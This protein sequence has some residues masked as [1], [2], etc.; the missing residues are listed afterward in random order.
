MTEVNTVRKRVSWR[1]FILKPIVFPRQARDKYR[2]STQEQNSFLQVT[3]ALE[4]FYPRK[5]R[6]VKTAVSCAV[7]A[8][9]I[10][11]VVFSMF[12]SMVLKGIMTDQARKKTPGLFCCDAL[13]YYK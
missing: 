13:F 7:V 3:G 12:M 4:R 10:L 1:H 6:T 2:E 8:V 11:V 5:R 9:S